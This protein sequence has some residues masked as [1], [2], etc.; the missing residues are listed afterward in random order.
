MS[1][2]CWVF[3]PMKWY[4]FPLAQVL[5][6]LSFSNIYKISSYESCN[7]F[8]VMSRYVFNFHFRSLF[9]FAGQYISYN[10]N[11][12]GDTGR[13]CFVPISSVFTRIYKYDARLGEE[14]N[15]FLSC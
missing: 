1:L 14:I 2:W 6:S 11:H 5:I 3:S 13:S 4:V 9:Y 7:L 15:M 10:V 12:S 8:L